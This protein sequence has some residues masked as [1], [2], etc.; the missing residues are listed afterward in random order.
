MRRL[1]PHLP[2]AG[3]SSRAGRNWHLPLAQTARGGGCRG[4]IGPCP[5]APLDEWNAADSTQCRGPRPLRAGQDVRCDR[6]DRLHRPRRHDGRPAGLVLAHRRAGLT[7]GPAAALLE[8]HRAGVPLVLVSGRTHEQVVE[9]ARIFAADGAIAELGATGQRGRPRE[10]PRPGELPAEFGG[11]TPMA[12]MAEL[13]VVE[14]LIAAAPRPAGVARALAHHPRRPTPCCAAGWTRSP[15]T[16]GWPSAAGLADAEGQRR[17]PGDLADDPGRRPAAAAGLPPDA[18]RH[19]QGRGDRLG[20]G[21]PRAA[22]PTTPSRSATA[23]ATWRWRRR[24]DRLWI[25]A[26]GAAVD[27]MAGRID[28]VPNVPRHRRRHGRG[29]GP[30]RPRRASGGDVA[31][32]EVAEAERGEHRRR[33][34]ATGSRRGTG[35]RSRPASAAGRSRR[36]RRRTGT[37]R[38][39]TPSCVTWSRIA[40]TNIVNTA[41]PT[42]ASGASVIVES[43]NASVPTTSRW[44]VEVADHPG[45]PQQRRRPAPSVTPDRRRDV[46]E[47]ESDA[48]G[49]HRDDD[50]GAG[51]RRP[52]APARR[53]TSAGAAASRGTG[54]ASV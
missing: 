2:R 7:D 17:D 49:D 9:A 53:T 10:H 12:V 23:S 48:A 24:S 29:L 20:P 38:G 52:T 32:G 11:R 22:P 19:H 39:S 31:A 54:V 47:A 16:P 51:T 43:Q 18:P 42:A 14:E 21:A 26:N 5:S 25:T 3:P 37:S 6:P 33:R 41:P 27:G 40:K 46:V 15:S 4:F 1:P 28:A 35:R 30:G 8:L 50:E 44:T 36:T 13:G 34:P 45:Q